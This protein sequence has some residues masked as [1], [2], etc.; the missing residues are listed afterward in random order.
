M[1]DEQF[2]PNS[3]RQVA[4]QKI[5]VGD[6]S[7][8]VPNAPEIYTRDWEPS[9]DVSLNTGVKEL[10]AQTHNVLL[11][12]TVEAKLGEQVAYLVE[13]QQGGVFVLQGF[14]DPAERSAVL[15]A[16]CPN[17]L[18]PYARESIAALVRRAGFPEFLLQPVNFDALY[19]EHVV[20]QQPGNTTAH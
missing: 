8:E 10:D 11:T 7:L 13:A 5:Y 9:V 2:D 19:H 18:F 16:Y 14:T 3:E 17:I 1:T 12:V 4:I 15:G 6:A 20:Q